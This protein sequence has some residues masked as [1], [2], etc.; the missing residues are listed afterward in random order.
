M[1][2]QNEKLYA[3]VFIDGMDGD[4]Y[5]SMQELQDAIAVAILRNAKDIVIRIGS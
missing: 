5:N 1:A 3:T 2:E 4:I